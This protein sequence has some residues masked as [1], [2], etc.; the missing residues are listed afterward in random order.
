MTTAT[1]HRTTIRVY[2]AVAD[3]ILGMQENAYGLDPWC[4]EAG[5]RYL[6]VDQSN[7]LPTTHGEWDYLPAGHTMVEVTIPAALPER[8][9][10]IC[11]VA[12]DAKNVATHDWFAYPPLAWLL[13]QISS[14]PLTE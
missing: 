1:I 2:P 11:A 3:I 7:A 13:V 9:H 4:H 5:W 6:H 14:A 12:A 8:Y 10:A